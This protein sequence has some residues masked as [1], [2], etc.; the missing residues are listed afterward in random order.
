LARVFGAEARA[1]KPPART[2]VFLLVTGEERGL[3]GTEYWLGHP[4]RPLKDVVL[5]LN[6]EMIGRPDSLAGGPGKLWLTGFERSNLGPAFAA[7]GLPVA[8]DARPEQHFFERSDNY[9]FVERGVVGQSLSSYNMHAEYHTVDDE[10]ATL[11]F[12]HM[13]GAVRAGLAA[14]RMVADGTLMPAWVKGAGS[15]QKPAPTQGKSGG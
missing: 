2:L 14:A 13:E 6:F 9:A 5:N 15:D 7:A 3:L 10:I 8:P 12:T 1:G 11:D 4:S